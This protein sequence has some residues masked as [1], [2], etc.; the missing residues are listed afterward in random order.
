MGRQA[1]VRDM[2]RHTSAPTSGTQTETSCTSSAGQSKLLRRQVG[3]TGPS[4]MQ[5]VLLAALTSSSDTLIEGDEQCAN[6]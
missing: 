4:E 2:V 1:R 3:E 5:L 6:C